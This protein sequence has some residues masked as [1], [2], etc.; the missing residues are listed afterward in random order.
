MALSDEQD[1]A[2]FKGAASLE[3]NADPND[4]L[5]LLAAVHQMRAFIDDVLFRTSNTWMGQYLHPAIHCSKCGG[6]IPE[7]DTLSAKLDMSAMNE[8]FCNG[9]AVWT[10]ASCAHG[11]AK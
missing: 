9:G 10:C 4:R 6:R 3:A 8:G 1:K 7:C 11:D 5:I 2:S